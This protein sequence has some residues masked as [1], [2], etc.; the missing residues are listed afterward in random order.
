MLE[1][2]ER[3]ILADAIVEANVI[4]GGVDLDVFTPGSREEARRALGF[5][6]DTTMLLYV[7]NG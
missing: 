4:P 7:A 1:Q 3:S 5:A 2:A 6:Q